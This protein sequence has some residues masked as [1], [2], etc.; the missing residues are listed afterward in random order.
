[1]TNYELKITSDIDVVTSIE[2]YQL[3]CWLKI[4]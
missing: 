2:M 3:A 4:H 1:L